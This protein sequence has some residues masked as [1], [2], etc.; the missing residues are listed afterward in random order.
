MFGRCLDGVWILTGWC[1]VSVCIWT[2]PGRFLRGV[3]KVSVTGQVGRG[4]F[5]TGQFGTGHF[6]TVQNETGQVG[7]DQ[8]GT[9]KVGTG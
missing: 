5:G 7:T 8:I 2:E 4:Q 1:L 3:W 9:G 6:W